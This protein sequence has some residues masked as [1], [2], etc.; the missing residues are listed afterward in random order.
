MR[1]PKEGPDS[2]TGLNNMA[3][4]L[5]DDRPIHKHFT[6]GGEFVCSK[7]ACQRK[8]REVAAAR[9][10]GTAVRGEEWDQ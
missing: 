1:F 5:G 8:R 3:L 4:W 7:A 6:R 9:D 2:V 10:A